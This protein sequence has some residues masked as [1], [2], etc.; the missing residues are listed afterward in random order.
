VHLSVYAEFEAWTSQLHTSKHQL[1]ITCVCYSAL[2]RSVSFNLTES[3]NKYE[4]ADL[5]L[6]FDFDLFQFFIIKQWA[7]YIVDGPCT[8]LSRQSQSCFLS[9]LLLDC[10]LLF[11]R[12]C[13]AYKS[14]K[15]YGNRCSQAASGCNRHREQNNRCTLINRVKLFSIRVGDS[16]FWHQSSLTLLDIHSSL[17]EYYFHILNTERISSTLSNASRG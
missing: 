2:F 1:T 3:C 6:F 16:T 4:R 11:D 14:G 17:L 7:T 9:Y 13:S 10:S 15:S 5:G 12:S 8:H